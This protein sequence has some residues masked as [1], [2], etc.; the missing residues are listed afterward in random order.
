MLLASLDLISFF[1]V[2][3]SAQCAELPSTLP[4]VDDLEPLNTL[5]DP[6]TFYN[7]TPLSSVDDWACRQQEIKQLVQHYF[8]GYL[9]DTSE[10]VNGP[11]KLIPWSPL[12]Y[13]HI[14]TST[15]CHR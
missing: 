14:F 7:G 11:F 10:E 6:F 12:A 4:G 9:P 5:P 3:A 2:R 13:S 1:I 15:D 8:Y